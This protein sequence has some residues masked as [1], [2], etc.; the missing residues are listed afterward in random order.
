MSTK[1]E[2]RPRSAEREHTIKRQIVQRT[3]GTN[4]N[5]C[6]CVSYKVLVRFSRKKRYFSAINASF[7]RFRPIVQA[8]TS[9][10]ISQKS[11]CF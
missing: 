2:A 6:N 7:L 5:A 3:G 1:Q 11:L 9:G 10:P 8:S 4:S